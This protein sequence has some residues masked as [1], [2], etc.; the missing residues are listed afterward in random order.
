MDLTWVHFYLL[1]SLF[2]Y[3]TAMRQ[4][5][6]LEDIPLS[7]GIYDARH[8]KTDFKVFVVV[9]PKEDWRAGALP[10]LLWV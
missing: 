6:G 4:V 9:I 1:K 7:Q 3:Y 2:L 5:L 8:E 10:I